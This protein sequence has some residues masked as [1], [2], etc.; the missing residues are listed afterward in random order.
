MNLKAVAVLLVATIQLAI[1]IGAAF[2]GMLLDHFSI[3]ATLL[4]GAALLIMATVVIEGGSRLSAP[5]LDARQGRRS[6]LLYVLAV[7]AN[8]C[9]HHCQQRPS[10]ANPASLPSLSAVLQRTGSPC[11]RG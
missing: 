2:G 1:M 4:A 6:M 9:P 10:S 7:S 5:I 11:L 3:G 8:L